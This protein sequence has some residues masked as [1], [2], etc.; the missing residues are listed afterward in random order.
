MLNAQ[1]GNLLDWVST[2]TVRPRMGGSQQP[3]T[4]CVGIACEFFQVGSGLVGRVVV[5]V[6]SALVQA[7]VY[8]GLAHTL[9]DVL[10]HASL[11][12]PELIRRQPVPPSAVDNI[13][14][15][16]DMQV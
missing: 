11:P 15:F 2:S 6:L 4:G 12:P 5:V 8:P 13:I 16:K 9:M 10:F 1:R 3:Q 14:A 7:K